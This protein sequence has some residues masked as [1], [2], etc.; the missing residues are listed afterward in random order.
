MLTNVDRC[1]ELEDYLKEEVET[2]GCGD[3]DGCVMLENYVKKAIEKVD[4][5]RS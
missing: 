3:V 5:I 1:V 4:V 2:A